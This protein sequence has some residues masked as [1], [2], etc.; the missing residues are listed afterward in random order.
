MLTACASNLAT[1]W[2][3]EVWDTANL[4]Q[5]EIAILFNSHSLRNSYAT[6]S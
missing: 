3:P 4:C 2:L 1:F 5:P 6:H